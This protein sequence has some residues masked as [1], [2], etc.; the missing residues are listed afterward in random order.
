MSRSLVALFAAV[1]STAGLVA[2]GGGGGSASVAPPPPPPGSRGALI[3]SGNATTLSTGSID[4]F[5][6]NGDMAPVDPGESAT[7]NVSVR[8]IVYSTITPQGTAINASG[9]LLVPAGGGCTG[10]RPLLSMQHG[11]ST[12][13]GFD[14]SDPTSPLVLTMAKYFASHGYVVV[15]PD[16]L[17]YGVSAGLGYHPYV[18]A[19]ADAAAVIDAVRATRAWF[20]SSAGMASGVSLSSRLFLTGTSEGGYISMATQR[21]MERDFPAEFVITANVPTSGP[22]DLANEVM[23]DL[24]TADTT[25]N[26]ATGSA[27][28]LLTSYQDIYGDIY[29][30]ASQVFQSPWS[31]TVEGLFPGPYG[32]A[33]AAM[34]DCKI[35]FNIDTTPSPP[36]G[37]CSTNALLQPQFVSDYE[38]GRAGTPG[39][40]AR[41]H[42]EAN[43]LL[44]SWKNLA[45]MTLCYGSLDPTA[46]ANAVAAGTYFGIGP[47]DVQTSGPAFITTWMAANSTAAKDY[48]G[49]VEAPGC[50]AYA[51]YAVFDTYVAPL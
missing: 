26:S 32:S 18:N 13:T 44:Q 7:C 5:N 43:G 16:Y 2:C 11:T 19:E 45:P 50:T 20:A 47:V 37:G 31:G 35:P 29:T 23:T 10:A 38:A 21:T 36:M 40:V 48:H 33:T 9:G 4:A 46:E 12:T 39:G 1:A 34:K 49:Q 41:A 25:Q 42:V 15:V 28:F 14:G 51:R 30:S 3:S 27:T 17:G 8:Q 24:R 6:T 22:Y